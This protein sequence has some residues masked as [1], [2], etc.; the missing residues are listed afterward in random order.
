MISSALLVDFT[1]IP[2][3]VIPRAIETRLISTPKLVTIG[4]CYDLNQF[5]AILL[6]VFK[7]KIPPIAE[8]KDPRRQI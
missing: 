1:N 6:G 7:M 8:S 4:T 2:G 5:N 3:R